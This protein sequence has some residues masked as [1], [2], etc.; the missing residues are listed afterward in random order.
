[1][2]LI[3][4]KSVQDVLKELRASKNPDK[5]LLN[6]Y[7]YYKID[8]YYE[9]VNSVFGTEHYTVDYSERQLYTTASGQEVMVCKCRITILDDDFQPILYKE[10]YGGREIHYNQTT[11]ID[12]GIKN[13]ATNAASSAFKEVWKSFGIFGL[14]PGDASDDESAG[15]GN[16]HTGTQKDVSNSDPQVTGEQANEYQHYVLVG[17]STVAIER[18]DTQTNKNVYKYR[19]RDSKNRIVYDVIFYPNRYKKVEEQLNRM[20]S[21]AQN[22]SLQISINAKKLAERDGVI[23]LVFDN[24][25]A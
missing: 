20:I 5:K 8:S 1:M 12:D 9:R 22:G 17:N 19:C 24:F 15:A 10:A 18:L 3:N 11:L 6:K 7:P 14:R 23:Q 13:L 16:S 25:V 2:R 4:G 21:S